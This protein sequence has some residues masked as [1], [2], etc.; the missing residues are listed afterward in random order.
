MTIAL[1]LKQW[2]WLQAEL[3]EKNK[4]LAAASEEISQLLSK[5]TDNTAIA[6]KEK[7]KV[8]VIVGQVTQKAQVSASCPAHAVL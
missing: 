4:E 6:E 3:A 2:L 7:A 1:G 8:A 5:I